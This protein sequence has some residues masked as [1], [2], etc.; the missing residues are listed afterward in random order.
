[1]DPTLLLRDPVVIRDRKSRGK[2]SKTGR[3]LLAFEHVDLTSTIMTT[4]RS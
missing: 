3:I 2:A 4:P 1:M